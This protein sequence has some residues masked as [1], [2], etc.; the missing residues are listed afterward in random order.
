V[1]GASALGSLLAAHPEAG[2]RVLVIWLPVIASDTGPPTDEVRAPLRDPR[3][4][5]FW[6]PNRWASPRM[7]ERAA[8]TMR[9][10]G[11][12]PEFNPHAIAWDLIALYPAGIPWEEPFPAATWWSGPVV[13]SLEQVRTALMESR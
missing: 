8:R 4:I 1:R 3:V 12:A 11:E 9:D 7:M 2:V 13:R 5:E 10:R 6:D